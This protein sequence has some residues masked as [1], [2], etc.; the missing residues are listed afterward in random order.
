[1]TLCTS[2]KEPK[3]IGR[4]DAIPPSLPSRMNL[5]AGTAASLVRSKRLRGQSRSSRKPYPHKT[6]I[7]WLRAENKNYY[8]LG[9]PYSRRA[10]QARPDM[11]TKPIANQAA[12]WRLFPQ[13]RPRD[14]IHRVVHLFTAVGG[15]QALQLCQKLSQHLHASVC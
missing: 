3:T 12:P 8:W 7:K 11:E 15:C 14:D 1:M 2:G 13:G 10:S 6:N 9:I 5:E 4:N